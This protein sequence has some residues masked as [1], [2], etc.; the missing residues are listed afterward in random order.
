MVSDINGKMTERK[1]MILE[2]VIME[3]IYTAE[4]VCSR[5]LTR[6]YNLGYSPATIRNEMSD[7]EE[8]ELLEQPYTSAGRIPSQKGYRYYVDY[9]MQKSKIDSELKN[10]VEDTYKAKLNEI[11][12]LVAITADLLSQLTNYTS[13]VLAPQLKK[14]AFRQLKIISIDR[15]NSLMVVMTDTGLIKHRMMQLPH[16]LNEKELKAVV[17]YLNRRLAGK[18]ID[19]INI[20]LIKEIRADLPRQVELLESALRLI[21]ETFDGS[22]K[23][24]TG[25]AINIL[26]QP[27]W[28]DVERVRQLFS[29]LEDQRSLTKVMKYS[30]GLQVRIGEENFFPQ[31][32]DCSL[33]VATYRLHGTPVGSIGILGPT[34]MDYSMVVAVVDHISNML[35]HFLTFFDI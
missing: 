4:P 24:V 25:G 14:C 18:T 22:E 10:K 19:Q 17:A 26:N 11:D 6:R 27:E 34:R 20:D 12:K 33:V 35:S 13:L 15:E 16:V 29:F 1:R 32:N 2:S 31:I 30:D 7:L 23:V 8:M 9:L 3:Y 28:Q 5:T 21:S